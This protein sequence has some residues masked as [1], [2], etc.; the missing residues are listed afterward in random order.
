MKIYTAALMKEEV[1]GHGCSGRSLGIELSNAYNGKSECPLFCEREEDIEEW[2][3]KKG[4]AAANYH[5]VEIELNTQLYGARPSSQMNEK[6]L[7]SKEELPVPL[8]KCNWLSYTSSR[9]L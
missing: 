9:N 2:I 5:V 3:A 6:K 7:L 4:L 8:P 1:L